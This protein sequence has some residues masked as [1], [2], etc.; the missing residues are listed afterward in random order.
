MRHTIALIAL[1]GLTACASTTADSNQDIS[2]STSPAG[3]QC[4]ATSSAGSWKLTKTPGIIS[5]K[6]AFAPLTIQC[7]KAGY[8]ATTQVLEADTRNRAY[9]NILLGGVPALADAYTGDGYEYAPAAIS[10]TL[11]QK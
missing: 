3:A 11:K 7:I 2:I 8:A 10:L 6:R 9:G 5:V 1:L 4:T